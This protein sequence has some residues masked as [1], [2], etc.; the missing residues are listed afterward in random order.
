MRFIEDVIKR[1]FITEKSNEAIA[2]GKYTFIV[3]KNATKTEIK[4]AV[5]KL[6]QVRVLKV[7]TLNF[8]GKQKRMGVHQGYRADWKKAVVKID[9]DPRPVTYTEKGGKEAVINKKLKTA[10]DEFG[11]TQ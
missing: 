8:K 1:P 5:E 3:D 4:Q 6:F 9:T 7:N 11:V 10:I 2:D